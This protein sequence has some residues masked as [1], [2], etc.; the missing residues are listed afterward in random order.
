M[1]QQLVRSQGPRDRGRRAAG[2]RGE[3][4]EGWHKVRAADLWE[5]GF[6][7]PFVA[8]ADAFGGAY[9]SHRS[10]VS[11]RERRVPLAEER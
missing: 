1:L 3:L 7:A 5:T 4:Y 11:M 8:G 2:G 9:D 10:R 6:A